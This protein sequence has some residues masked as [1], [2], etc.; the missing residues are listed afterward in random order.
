MSIG[1]ILIGIAMMVVAVPFVINPLLKSK[2]N[3]HSELIEEK[4]DSPGDRYNEL[5]LAL[6]DLEFDHQIGKISEDDYSG[7]RETMLAQAAIA[8]EAQEKHDAEL[9][10][11]L[12]QSIQLRREKQSKSRVC[13]HCGVTL[14][15]TDHY[16]RGCGMPVEATCPK[17]GGKLQPKDLFCNICGAPVTVAKTHKSMEG[18][19]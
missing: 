17:C 16:C 4:L 15:V 13:S 7:L 3:E 14:E 9:D 5:L 6:R 2:Q 10:A 1:A 11:Q 8:L 19:L 18:T 12:E